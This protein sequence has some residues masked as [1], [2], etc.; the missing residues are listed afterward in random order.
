MSLDDSTRKSA[1]W[2]PVA[3]C[4]GLWQPDRLPLEQP[5]PKGGWLEAS[6]TRLPGL[7]FADRIGVDWKW[8][9]RSEEGS[10][11]ILPRSSLGMLGVFAGNIRGSKISGR[12]LIQ[13]LTF[14]LFNVFWSILFIL[15]YSTMCYRILTYVR[16]CW[17]VLAHF[18]LCYLVWTQSKIIWLILANVNVCHCILLC[19]YLLMFIFIQYHCDDFTDSLARDPGPRMLNNIAIVLNKIFH[20]VIQHS[21]KYVHLSPRPA[22]SPALSLSQCLIWNCGI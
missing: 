9:A 10:L 22:S 8:V 6:K 12:Y 21:Q 17:R 14:V 2:H 15:S 11:I 3:A 13:F 16:V 19:V 7:L 4:G 20:N 18:D 1:L 5:S